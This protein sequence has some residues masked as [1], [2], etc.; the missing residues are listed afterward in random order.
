MI[1]ASPFVDLRSGTWAAVFSPKP[2]SATHMALE[3]HNTHSLDKLLKL[4][5]AQQHTNEALFDLVMEI[6]E[7]QKQIEIP[8]IKN[9]LHIIRK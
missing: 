4:I 7:Q 5:E 9:T 8:T 1:G 6:R 3:L 2:T